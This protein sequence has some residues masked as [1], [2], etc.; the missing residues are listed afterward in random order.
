MV[1]QPSIF[2]MVRSGNFVPFPC[3]HVNRSLKAQLAELF[4][5]FYSETAAE[6]LMYLSG[7]TDTLPEGLTPKERLF[8]RAVRNGQIVKGT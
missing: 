3:T 1:S 2:K 8:F 6:A 7:H 5:C 4:E